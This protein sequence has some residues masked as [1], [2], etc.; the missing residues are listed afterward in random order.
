MTLDLTRAPW[1]ELASTAPSLPGGSGAQVTSLLEVLDAFAENK[2]SPIVSSPEATERIVK[3]I[4]VLGLTKRGANGIALTRVGRTV[5]KDPSPE[6]LFLVLHSRVA[7]FGEM[8]ARIAEAPAS[9][10]DL[11]RNAQEDFLMNWSSYDQLRRR[12]AWLHNIGLVEDGPKRLHVITEHGLRMLQGLELQNAAEL[13]ASLAEASKDATLPLAPPLLREALQNLDHENRTL[14]WSYLTKDPVAALTFLTELVRNPLRKEEAVAA[15]AKAFDISSS[16]SKSFVDAAGALGIHEYVGKF[17]I[18]STP[19]GVEWAQNASPLHLVRLLHI[20]FLGVGEALLHLDDT[21][22]TVGEIHSRMFRD[23]EAAPRQSRTAGVVRYLSLA[24]AITPIGFARYTISGLGRALKDELPTATTQAPKER[25]SQPSPAHGPEG[26]S[27]LEAFLVELESASRDSANSARFER[28]CADAF[29]RLGVEASHLGGPG[30]TDVL[31]TVRSNLKVIARAIID[32]KSSAGQLNEGS[33]KFDA[34]REHA[35]KHDADLIAVIAPSFDGS[36]RLAAWAVA[37]G[38][39]LYTASDLG[40]L[41]TMHETY[42]FSAEDVADLLSVDRREEVAARREQHMEQLQ[43]L[44]NV[45]RELRTESEQ[46]QPE[47]ITAR[48]IGRVMRRDGSDVSDDLVGAV[49]RFLEQPE[50]A[51][52]HATSSG[53]YTLPSSPQVAAGR[54][55][56]LARAIVGEIRA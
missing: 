24:G 34:L 46:A 47:P 30:K 38:V 55:R 54:L 29:V 39:V 32:A 33:V 18:A 23:A 12:L 31:V 17:E 50:V 40:R 37:N 43:L 41:L 48:D 14:A 5:L 15:V 20:R 11:A 9:V 19:L 52:V 8:L 44:S 1:A 27:P 6:N 42:P 10:E 4:G 35:G 3:Q 56:A 28:A 7:Y 25:L 13:K 22:R 51:A 36:G 2:D 53:K 49:L 21:P 45:M 26:Q 16:S